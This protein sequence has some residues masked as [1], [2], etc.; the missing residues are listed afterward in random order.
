MRRIVPSSCLPWRPFRRRSEAE[1]SAMKARVL[2]LLALVAGAG[3]PAFGQC[4]TAD[5]VFT[6]FGFAPTAINT[7][8]AAQTVTCTIAVTDALSGATSVGCQFQSPSFQKQLSCTATT[9]TSGTPQNGVFSC[10]VTFP[11]YSEAGVWKA[12]LS[13]SDAVGND[14]ALQWFFFPVGFPTDLTVTSD[15][16]AVAPGLTDL[17][18]VPSAV[19][20]SA[21]AQNV[22]CNMTVTDAK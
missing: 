18:L 12:N 1:G 10:T 14:V 8:A 4:D 3:G 16:D 5:P 9:P 19:T 20:V 21:A 7:T 13:A 15:P 11:R 6:S 17:A 2:V 22:A